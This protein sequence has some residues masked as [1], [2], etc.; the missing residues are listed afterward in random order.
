MSANAVI[1]RAATVMWTPGRIGTRSCRPKSSKRA[2]VSSSRATSR[3]STSPAAHRKCNELGYGV[4]GS[5]LLLHLVTNPVGAFL[6]GPQAALETDW[7]R[8]LHRRFGV[9]FN[10]LYTITN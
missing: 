1:K 10:R 3:R 9:T 7:K 8:E 2:C 4:E 5:G 6:P